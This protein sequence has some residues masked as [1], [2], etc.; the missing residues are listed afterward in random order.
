MHP[1]LSFVNEK[2]ILP[3]H[4]KGLQIELRIKSLL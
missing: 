3:L 4:E 1:A 2:N